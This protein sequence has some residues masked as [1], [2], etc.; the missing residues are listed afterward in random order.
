MD[1][2]FTVSLYSIY[3]WPVGVS[4]KP[5]TTCGAGE[6]GTLL[7]VSEAREHNTFADVAIALLTVCRPLQ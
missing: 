1:F 2:F 5:I 4:P 6:G 3:L 7:S